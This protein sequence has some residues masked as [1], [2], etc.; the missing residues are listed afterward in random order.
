MN[1]LQVFQNAE[2]GKVR[3]VVIDGEPWLVGKD[4]TAILGYQN[5]SKALA[6]HVDDDDK[7][8][9]ESLSSLG[10]RGGWLINESGFYSLVM[11]SKLPTAKKFK[12]WVTSEVLPTIRKTGAYVANPDSYMIT[13]PVERAKK[14]IEEETVRQEQAKQLEAQKPMVLFASSV[15]TS[16]AEILVGELAKILKQNGVD[17]GEKRLFAWLREHGYLINR[18]GTDWNMPTQYSMERGLFRIKETTVNHSDGHTTVNKTPKVTGK[19]QIYFVN[20]FLGVD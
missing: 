1:Q 9:N 6:D 4:V 12:R 16:K 17:M 20:K 7:L 18:K 11:G 19:G 15:S 8:N 5:A 2:F 10:Q 3:T 14:W 13:D